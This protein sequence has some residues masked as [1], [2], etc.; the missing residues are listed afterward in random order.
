LLTGDDGV[1]MF[2]TKGRKT[3][4]DGHLYGHLII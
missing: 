3:R 2:V 1:E 4:N